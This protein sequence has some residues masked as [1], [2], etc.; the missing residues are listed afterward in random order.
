MG[1]KE[2]WLVKIVLESTKE[3]A[4]TVGYRLAVD[5][6]DWSNHLLQLVLRKNQSYGDAWR[7]Q[8]WMGNLSRI[9]SK[10]HRLRNMLWQSF[11]EESADEAVEDTAQD[12]AVLSF[13]FVMNRR[14]QN[15]W[16]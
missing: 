13:F 2:D 12:L 8:G 6:A 5:F 10:G 7:A 1:R 15:R 4:L 3:E 14:N 9:M 16:G 11:E